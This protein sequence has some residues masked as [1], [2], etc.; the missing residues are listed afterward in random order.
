MASCIEPFIKCSNMPASVR[1]YTEILDF[2]LREAPD[3]DPQSF[4]SRYAQL[5]RDGNRLHLSAHAGDGVFGN[6]IFVRVTNLDDLYQTFVA[7]GLNVEDP[8]RLPALTMPPVEQTWGVKEFAVKDP[9]GN[10]L[11]FGQSLESAP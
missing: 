11:T 1:F 3:P 6:V 5:G 8:E 2:E 10:R 9:D 4:M 7:R